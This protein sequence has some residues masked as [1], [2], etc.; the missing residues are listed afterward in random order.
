MDRALYPILGRKV[1]MENPA[2]FM[3]H[4]GRMR[5]AGPGGAVGFDGLG[6][7]KG[8]VLFIYLVG[9]WQVGGGQRFLMSRGPGSQNMAQ[10]PGSQNL[11]KISDSQNPVQPLGFTEPGSRNYG[12]D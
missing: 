1:F 10:I 6:A 2:W 9:R 4:A 7:V 11:V 3:S 12:T 8:L 5:G